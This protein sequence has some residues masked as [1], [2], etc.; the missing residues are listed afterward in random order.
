MV[1][2]PGSPTVRRFTAVAAATLGLA[3][4]ST[5]A[6][7]ATSPSCDPGPVELV[8][9]GDTELLAGQEHVQGYLLRRTLGAGR[10]CV[11]PGA[12]V[13][14]LA[15]N[16]GASTPSVIR[17]ATTDADGRAVFRVR[18]PYSVVLTGRTVAANG[19]SATE[20]ATTTLRVATRLSFARRP[21][22]ACHVAVAGRTYPAKPGTTVEVQ[23][24]RG[25]YDVVRI[26]RT[27]VRQDGT[28][29]TTVTVP[30]GSTDRLFATI[31]QTARNAY[32]SSDRR[33]EVAQRTTTCGQGNSNSEAAG[34]ALTQTFEPFNTTTA[35]GGSWWGE[36]V[37]SNRTQA[38][39]TYDDYDYEVYELLRLGTAV[40]VGKNSS[41]DAV[42]VTHRSLAPGAEIRDRVALEAANCFETPP[43]GVVPFSSSPGPAFPAGTSV[44]GRTVY[45]TTDGTSVS[46]RVPL[47]VS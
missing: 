28:W 38:T 14:L 15:R 32:G 16:A 39:L 31:Q 3:L 12:T 24:Q 27:T 40:L 44:A 36:R 9:G 35:V 30:C 20:S 4:L 23:R 26:G 29:Q 21:L 1:A 5:P 45:V 17:T 18:P 19:F 37:I 6:A 43:P 34:T 11:V 42:L 46:Q 10:S 33:I 22:D 25:T 8:T 47:T 41:S 13:E 2:D 7:V